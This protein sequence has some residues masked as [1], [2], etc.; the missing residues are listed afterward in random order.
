MAAGETAGKVRREEMKEE[1]FDKK[2]KEL[3][4]SCTET[5]AP[6]VWDRIETGLG[7]RRR[8]VVWRRI[9]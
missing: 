1:L 3:L 2:I 6:E 5:P 8:Q 7:R 4:D 9:A